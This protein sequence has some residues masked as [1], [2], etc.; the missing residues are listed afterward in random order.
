MMMEEREGESSPQRRRTTR[1]IM[2]Q[3]HQVVVV[4]SL[5]PVWTVG[6]EAQKWIA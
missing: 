3:P 4:P 6:G 5:L 1:M 2:C